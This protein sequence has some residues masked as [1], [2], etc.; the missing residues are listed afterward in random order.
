VS[1]AR[2]AA[3]AAVTGTV[4]VAVAVVLLSNGAPGAGRTSSTAGRPVDAPPAAS[5][6]RPPAPAPAPAPTSGPLPTPTSAPAQNGAAPN[7]AAP[8]IR[9]DD[10]R[11]GP[12]D[13]LATCLHAGNVG[14]GDGSWG[15]YECVGGSGNLRIEPSQQ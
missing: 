11:L 14:M 6:Q 7:G 15:D 3:I 10:P 5:S 9:A 12:F 2:H 13:A 4:V 8:K 1:I